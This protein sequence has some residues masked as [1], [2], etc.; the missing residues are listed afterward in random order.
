VGGVPPRS[1][2]R[3]HAGIASAHSRPTG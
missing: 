3:S 2:R 1:R